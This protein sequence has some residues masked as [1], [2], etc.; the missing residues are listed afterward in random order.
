VPEICS[1]A[2]GCRGLREWT[3]TFNICLPEVG[4]KIVFDAIAGVGG[5]TQQLCNPTLAT[6]IVNELP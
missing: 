5:P 4:P 2:C 1:G 6:D 3:A